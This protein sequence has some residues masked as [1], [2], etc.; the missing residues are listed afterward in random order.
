M[1]VD[2]QRRAVRVL[3]RDPRKQVGPSW[4]GLENLGLDAHFGKLFGNIVRG[5][6]F[7]VRLSFAPVLGVKTDQVLAQLHDL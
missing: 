4:S 1:A 2:N 3:P 6:A 5:N 7:R